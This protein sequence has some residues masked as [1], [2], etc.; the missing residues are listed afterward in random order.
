MPIISFWVPFLRRS[1]MPI[2][3]QSGERTGESTIVNMVYWTRSP[4][5]IDVNVVNFSCQFRTKLRDPDTAPSTVVDRWRTSSQRS[6][7]VAVNYM[8]EMQ[9]AMSDTTFI[10]LSKCPIVRPDESPISLRRLGFA[11]TWLVQFPILQFK[12]SRSTLKF[13]LR[14]FTNDIIMISLCMRI[15]IGT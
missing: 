6:C 14:S 15:S 12:M 11:S 1:T 9:Y 8:P 7:K 10:I 13:F 5:S 3:L 4:V 2:A